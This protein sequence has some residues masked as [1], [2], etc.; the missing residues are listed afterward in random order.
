M[1]YHDSRYVRLKNDIF[2]LNCGNVEIPYE[3]LKTAYLK[4][5]DLTVDD[6]KIRLY[7]KQ[8]KKEC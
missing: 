1:Y 8:H 7:K 5:D 3:Q 4:N 6:F 2:Y